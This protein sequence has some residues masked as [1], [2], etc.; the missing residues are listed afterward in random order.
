M[1]R[2]K[3]K[4]S[5]VVVSNIDCDASETIKTL[6]RFTQTEAKLH[7]RGNRS[8]KLSKIADLII[9]LKQAR[10]GSNRKNSS[11]LSKKDFENLAV[12][13]ALEAL[14]V[15]D[16]SITTAELANYRSNK[17]LPPGSF[18]EIAEKS[19]YFIEKAA[20]YI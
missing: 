14:G 13:L 17:H 16:G 1:P 20:K 18:I 10:S 3:T 11:V 15:L 19:R 2:S 9:A 12:N 8:I 5:T 4:I 7:G 6:D